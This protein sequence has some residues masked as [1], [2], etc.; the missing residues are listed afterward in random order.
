MSPEAVNTKIGADAGALRVHPRRAVG[1]LGRL[2]TYYITNLDRG[3]PDSTGKGAGS[4]AG[5]WYGLSGSMPVLPPI[6]DRLIEKRVSREVDGN[7]LMIRQ[8][9]GAWWHGLLVLVVA[10]IFAWFA[11]QPEFWVEADLPVPEWIERSG[12][13]LLAVALA[14]CAAGVTINSTE[15]TLTR[16]ELRVRVGPVP[17]K[18]AVHLACADIRVVAFRE[19][20]ETGYATTYSLVALAGDGEHLLR[21]GLKDYELTI[22]YVRELRDFLRLPYSRIAPLD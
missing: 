4:S 12:A 16:E 5:L 11:W 3:E 9:W 6:S 15:I 10:L 17:W 20:A 13:L 18:G 7:R 14:Y 8:R 19:N 22:F 1:A 2:V 21:G